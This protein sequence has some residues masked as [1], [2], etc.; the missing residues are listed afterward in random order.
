VARRLTFREVA[1]ERGAPYPAWLR[2]LRNAS[3]VYLIRERSALTTGAM[4][5][6]GESHTGK[7]YDTLTRHF[8]AW[9]RLKTFWRGKGGPNDPGLTYDRN[10]V[11]VAVIV[12]RDAHRAVDLQDR[13][14]RR[15]CPRDNVTGAES[16]PKAG[17]VFDVF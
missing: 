6:I 15:Y 11:E 8:Q 5:Y 17:D 9:A 2:E 10:V 4:L 7:L 16:C 1:G 14:I 12:V 3:G 13:L